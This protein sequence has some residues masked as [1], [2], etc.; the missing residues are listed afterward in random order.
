MC[1]PALR[2]PT[3]SPDRMTLDVGMLVERPIRLWQSS[4][5]SSGIELLTVKRKTSPTPGYMYSDIATVEAKIKIADASM[6]KRAGAAGRTAAGEADRLAKRALSLIDDIR[7]ELLK[8][9]E[10]TRVSFV[11]VFLRNAK[12]TARGQHQEEFGQW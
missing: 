10:A 6:P 2:N 3:R 4:L 8:H 7:S 9:R 12:R 1:G 5:N 11:K